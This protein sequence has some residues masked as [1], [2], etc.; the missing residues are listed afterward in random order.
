VVGCLALLG[1][2]GVGV[3][4]CLRYRREG[5]QEEA[6]RRGEAEMGE[7]QEV[8]RDAMG[9]GGGRGGVEKR[10]KDEEYIPEFQAELPAPY[11]VRPP[12]KFTEM[13]ADAG[14]VELPTDYNYNGGARPA[15]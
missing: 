8:E 10:E 12:G 14:A 9:R 4:L 2:I 3:F 5:K 11:T 13:A 15:P 1:F 7:K 6:K